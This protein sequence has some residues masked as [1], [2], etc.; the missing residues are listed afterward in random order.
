MYI[1]DV[2]ERKVIPTM[3][4]WVFNQLTCTFNTDEEYNAFKEKAN[5]KS[6]YNS[7]IP[8]PSVLEGTRSPHLNPQ[9]I[10]ER[11]NK[12]HNTKFITLEGI[13]TAGPEWESKQIRDI[14]QNLKAHEETGYYNWY[15][16]NVANWGVKW[17]A[18]NCSL[19]ELQDF[20]TL[21]FEFESPWDS[22]IQFV[23]E[24]SKLYPDANFELISGSIESDFHREYIFQNGSIEYPLSYDS[25]K[26]AVE[27]GKWGGR[28]NWQDLFEE[29]E[30]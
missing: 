13:I 21:I 6:L 7:F 18:S 12:E 14:I 19:K 11:V 29:D 25:F 3:P 15:D 22:P 2:R 4:N 30:A 27:C 1:Q 9:D 8:M 24:L 17:D 16:W 20:N 10:I 23:M 28:E 5:V 26:E